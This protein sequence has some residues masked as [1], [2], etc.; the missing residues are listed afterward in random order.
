VQAVPDRGGPYVQGLAAPRLGVQSHGPR[1]G[2]CSPAPLHR[3][4]GQNG[5]CQ[6]LSQFDPLFHGISILILS[7][8]CLRLKQFLVKGIEL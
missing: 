2:P 7:C 6:I 8:R 1:Q 5:E 4:H 3:S